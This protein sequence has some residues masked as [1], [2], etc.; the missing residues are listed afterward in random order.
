[1]AAAPAPP[2]EWGVMVP[3]V[4]LVSTIVL[5]LVM[6]MSFE[7]MQGMWGYHTGNKVSNLLIHPI[8][9]MFSGDDKLP[10]N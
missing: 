3:I 5:F 10:E 7:L 6:L 9:K 8:A 2:A 4:S 1:M